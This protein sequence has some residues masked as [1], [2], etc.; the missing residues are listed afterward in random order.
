MR[1]QLPVSRLPLL[2]ALV[3]LSG[4][5]TAYRQAMAQAE[6]AA[7]RGDFMSAAH[8]YRA[9]CAASPDDEKACSRAAVFAQKATDQAIATA[10]PACDAGDLDP[11]LPPLL[12]ARELI[13]DHPEVNSMLAKAS[14]VHTERCS[15]W[16]PEGPLT[17]ASAGLACLQS[18]A[19]QLP[20]PSFQ[21]LLAERASQ[22]S[23]RL[24]QLA[25]TAQ[26][27]SASGA[28]SVLWSAAQCLA[29]ATDTGTRADQA[30]QGF[31]AQSA[32]P[33]GIRVEG[34]MPPPIAEQ[35]SHLCQ[36][37]AGNLAP[38]ARCADQGIAP[39]QP[40]PLEIRVNALIQ[41]AMERI[42]E[43]V[44]SVRYV[45]GTRQV[46]N[47]AYLEARERFKIAERNLRTAEKMKSDKD[48]A[49]EQSKKSHD[50]SSVGSN[51]KTPCDEARQLSDDLGGR[52]HERDEALNYLNNTP[53]TL[54]EEVWDDFRYSVLTH[55]WS[56]G[57]RFSVQSSSP[58]S[59]PTPEQAGELNFEDQEHVGFSPGGLAPDPLEVPT[60][61]VYA[62]A[63]TQQVAPVV[64]SAVQQ[65]SVARGT[66]RRAQCS[67]LPAD[68]SPAWVQCWA[69]ATLWERG[70]EPQATEFLGLLATSGGATNPLLCR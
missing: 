52:A 63:F 53:E 10:R 28:A 12:A 35:L 23:S 60:S 47:P 55:R 50:A 66:A 67:A 31:L 18:R 49:C 42:A 17:E 51:G 38:A 2:L 15:K 1:S 39:G 26:G 6:D 56:S 41:R 27:P 32:I 34:R 33:V 69:E 70:Q 13:P 45:S 59:A 25:T 46:R 57:Y 7:V 30:R 40:D 14:Q 3:V 58:G 20:V 11:C 65:E 19:N 36:N 24:A 9:A 16:K 64:F 21:S 4:C 37:V 8:A 22:L 43:D 68:W 62:S 29:P 44:R 54:V 48:R 5:N 61:G